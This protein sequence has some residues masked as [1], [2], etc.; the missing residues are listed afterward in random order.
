MHEICKFLVMKV[1]RWSIDFSS[2]SEPSV[3]LNALFNHQAFVAYSKL[4]A[5]MPEILFAAV[6]VNNG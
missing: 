1:N 5:F 4:R 6:H 2:F 3:A